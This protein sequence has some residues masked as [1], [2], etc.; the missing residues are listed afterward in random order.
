MWEREGC[1]WGRIFRGWDKKNCATRQESVSAL[2]HDMSPIL[3][4][5]KR[6]GGVREK[7]F[8]EGE[9]PYVFSE[10]RESHHHWAKL[11]TKSSVLN[12]FSSFV[13]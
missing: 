5:K 4:E 2:A 7:M 6:G 13:F 10:G 11:G 12:F 1:A 9:Q 3:L 8:V